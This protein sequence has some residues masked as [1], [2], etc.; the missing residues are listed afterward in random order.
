MVSLNE[1]LPCYEEMQR[2][3]KDLQKLVLHYVP[4]SCSN[5]LTIPAFKNTYLTPSL[6]L[7]SFRY[8]LLNVLNY[9]PGKFKF[10][11]LGA[12]I[13]FS[14]YVFGQLHSICSPCSAF[15]FLKNIPDCKKA[16]DLR[17]FRVNVYSFWYV[18]HYQ[19]VEAEYY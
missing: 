14:I 16:L 9:L 6:N 12:L 2:S 5:G 19:D 4:E 15:F 17:G 7:S 18:P 10:S 8:L 1:K 11:A 3:F 13:F